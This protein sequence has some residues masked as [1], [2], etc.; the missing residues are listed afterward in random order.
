VEWSFANTPAQWFFWISGLPRQIFQC[1]V[2]KYDIF[3][4]LLVNIKTRFYGNQ[5]M[6]NFNC[7]AISLDEYLSLVF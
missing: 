5:S 7:E 6:E 2:A 1:P 4:A 3:G